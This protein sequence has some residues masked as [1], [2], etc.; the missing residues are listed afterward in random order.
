MSI[1]FSGVRPLALLSCIVI[2]ATANAGPNDALHLYAALGYGHDDNLLRVPDNLPGFDNTRAD[3]WWSREGGLIFDKTYSLQRISLIAKLSKYDFD[4]FKQLDYDGKDI[5]ANWYWQVG[6]HLSGKIGATY[7]QTLAP[8]TDFASDQRNL[9]RSRSRYAE[10]TWR[11]HSAWQARAGYQHDV[12][13]YELAGERFNNRSEN[14]TELELDYI[15]RSASTVGLVARRVRGHYPFPRP[16]GANLL[17]DDFTQDELK[18]RVK[19]NVTGSSSIDALIG[20]TRR[21]QPSYGPGKTSGAAGRIN[22]TWQPLGKTSYTASVWRDFAPLESTL[23][24]YTLNNGAA[25]GA[26]WEAS[27]KIRVNADFSAERRSYSARQALN[28]A[29]AG[30]LRDS[31]RTGSLRATWTPR[32]LLQVTAGAAHQSRSGS[33]TIGTGSFRSNSIT[34]SASA[35]F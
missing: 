10:G 17:N 35:Q 11:F 2:A 32:P 16:I 9:R 7:N 4:H 27:A 34:L 29:G 23:V 12:Y 5:Q 6:N 24:S 33:V 22:L 8:Y 31:I 30:D 19:W 20:H 21:D 28:L 15:A 3:S 13:A 1:A 25:V 26:Q 14:T 18:A